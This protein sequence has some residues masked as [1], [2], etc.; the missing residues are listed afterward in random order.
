MTELAP[1]DP[2][3]LTLELAAIDSTTYHEGNAGDFLAEF[4]GGR[5]WEVEKTAVAQPPDSGS[6]GERCNVYAGARGETPDIVFS[7]HLDTVPPYIAPTEDGDFLY[8]RGVCDAKGIIAAQIAAAE[9]LRAAGYRIGL[10]YVSGEERDSAGAMLANEH[11]A[12]AG[13]SSMESPRITGWR[14]PRRAHCALW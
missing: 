4:L 3:A 8:G 6:Q 2:I 12:G 14:W 7:T 1:I 10:L 13:F 11:P 5:G 9:A